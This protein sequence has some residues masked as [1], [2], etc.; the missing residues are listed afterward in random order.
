[1]L[2]SLTQLFIQSLY[3]PPQLSNQ[4]VPWVVVHH[5]LVCYVGSFS[6]V[7]QR[8][9][10]LLQECII[11]TN[12]GDHQTVT[13]APNRLLQNRSQLR[14]PVRHVGL[15]LLPLA[16]GTLSQNAYHLPQREERLVDIDAFLSLLALCARQTYPLRPSQVHQFQLATQHVARP[17]PVVALDADS[18]D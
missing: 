7:G 10:V 6:S 16:S 15:L 14:V 18:Q 1:M 3:L 9:Q 13:V 11:W 2:V 17:R 8:R 12:T 5:R 4:F